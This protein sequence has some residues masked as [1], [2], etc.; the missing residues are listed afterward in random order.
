MKIQIIEGIDYKSKKQVRL[1]IDHGMIVSIEPSSHGNSE[2]LPYIA[3]GLIDIQVNGYKGFDFNTFPISSSGMNLMTHALLEEG[4]TT[5]FPTLISN[6][7]ELLSNLL[8]SIVSTCRTYPETNISIGGIHIEGPFISPEDGPRG[9]HSRLHIKPPDW[10]LFSRWQE[11]AEGRIKIITLSP[12]WPGSNEFI[13][14]CAKCGV[15]VAIGHTSATPQQ[16]AEAVDAGAT[17]STHLGNGSHL[18]IHRHLNY[19]WAQL[20][21]D[22]LWSS[23]I[24]D[25]FHLPDEVLKV[26]LKVK[27]GKTMLISDSTSFAGMEPGDYSGH[28]GGEVTLSDEG[29]L[30]TRE[31]PQLLAGSAQSILWCINTLLKRKITSFEDSLDMAS[32][33]PATFFNLYGKTGIHAGGIA[34]LILFDYHG[35][36]IKIRETI[37]N[38]NLVYKRM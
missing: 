2:D 22:N 24:A 34:D 5:Y 19:I 4:V 13:R 1:I 15:V 21:E 10:E 38:G 3:P 12:E 28:I 16:I 20:A 37:K 29:R 17:L 14:K 33:K 31:N 9:A 11:I 6:S 35:D 23:I 18:M 26:F 36:N 27:A 7:D 30:S 25:G 8:E 32:V